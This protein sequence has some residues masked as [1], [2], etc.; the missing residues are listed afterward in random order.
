M[1][2]SIDTRR[3]THPMTE[4]RIQLRRAWDD[5]APRPT[6][7]DLPAHWGTGT[8]PN[9]IARSFNRP[10]T[11]DARE[12]IS[13]E[14]ARVPGLLSAHL[15]ENPLNLIAED[16]EPRVARITD[17]KPFGNRLVLAIDPARAMGAT[18]GGRSRW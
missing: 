12:A 17:L 13:L 1:A 18:R 7:I 8:I 11:I 16:D 6:R 15:N 3:D 2:R 9:R 10:R 14:F 4:H 5:D